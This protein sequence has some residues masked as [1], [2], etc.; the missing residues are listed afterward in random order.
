MIV[1]FARILMPLLDL[2]GV[3]TGDED[4]YSVSAHAHHVH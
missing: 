1:I 2:A 4:D 3:A